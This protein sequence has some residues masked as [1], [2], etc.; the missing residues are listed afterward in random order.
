MT[1]DPLLDADAAHMR[2]DL[3][4]LLIEPEDDGAGE[5][6]STPRS[7]T[8][9]RYELRREIGRGS[10]GIVYEAHDPL[11]ERSVAVKTIQIAFATSLEEFAT[12]EQRFFAEARI[13]AGL[14]H[15]GIVVVHDVGRDAG[16]G[17]LFIAM[18]HLEGRPLSDI[19]RP[20]VALPWREALRITGRLAEA[21]HYA[22]SRGVVHRDIKPANIMLLSSGEPKIMDFGIAKTQTAHLQLTSAGQTIGTP[23]YASPEQALGD[24]VDGRS[25]L[26]S[27]GAIAYALLTGRAAFA[28]T[29]LAGIVLRVV[30]SDPPPPSSLARDLPPEVDRL[31]ARALAKDPAARHPDGAAL[32]EDIA[33]LLAGSALPDAI[34]AAPP[35]ESWP[36]AEPNISAPPPR[37]GDTL[38]MRRHAGRPGHAGAE[39]AAPAEPHVEEPTQTAPET[40]QAP[41]ESPESTPAGASPGTPPADRTS[42]RP[43]VLRWLGPA[44]AALG[45]VVA[46]AAAPSLRLPGQQ[47]LPAPE[48]RRADE[49]SARR[50]APA[51]SSREV[52]RLSI[53][54]ERP[55][56]GASVA[57]WVDRSLVAEERWDDRLEEKTRLV[58]FGPDGADA[59]ILEPGGHD[60][61]VEIT[62]DG[63][64]SSSRIWGQVNSGGTRLLRAKFGGVLRKSLSL[65]WE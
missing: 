56:A 1:N 42:T 23:L 13:A 27:L 34:E 63:K 41:L 40:A 58:S 49:T 9:G 51:A 17:E 8:I 46:F 14:A 32:A 31:I 52:G 21:L 65:E 12:F 25:D 43:A 4:S 38:S 36:H 6:R 64:R 54:F 59:L 33:E 45:V 16:T 24:P 48:S 18:E 11:L 2:R 7:R 3:S 53:R 39:L 30:G 47:A 37:A 26:F 61:E 22:H 57:V 29:N 20:A 19:L 5:S 44:I 50:E 55:P 35:A 62:R 28:A 10:M 15:P 60:V